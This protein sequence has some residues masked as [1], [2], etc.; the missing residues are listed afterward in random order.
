MLRHASPVGAT[1]GSTVRLK[2]TQ[3]L[4]AFLQDYSVVSKES[5]AKSAAF[6]H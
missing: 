3:S 2:P 4:T 1:V 6:C 5:I